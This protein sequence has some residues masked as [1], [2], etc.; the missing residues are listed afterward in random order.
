[1][2]W[3]GSFDTR[4]QLVAFAPGIESNFDSPLGDL[5]SSF[6]TE[7]GAFDYEATSMIAS[8]AALAWGIGGLPSDVSVVATELDDGTKLWV[9]PVEGIALFVIEGDFRS[10]ARG[11]LAERVDVE[12]AASLV[13]YDAAGNETFRLEGLFA[14][15]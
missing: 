11:A 1:M 7:T 4:V 14:S 2:A 3:D 12:G 9:R 5:W 15:E 8:S 13:G 10:G 6:D